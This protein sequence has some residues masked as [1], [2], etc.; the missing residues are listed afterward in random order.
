[1]RIPAVLAAVAAL[2]LAVSGQDKAVDT[3]LKTLDW[4]SEWDAVSAAASESGKPIF[5]LNV[6]GDLDGN[7]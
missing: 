2:S 5:W 6:V 1:M 7:T 3:V 4:H